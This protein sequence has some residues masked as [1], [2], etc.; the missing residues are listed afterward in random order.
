MT[1]ITI[2]AAEPSDAEAIHSILRCPGVVAGTLQLPWRP[3]EYTRQRFGTSSG[4]TYSLVAL[5]EARV[6][7]QLGL[8]VHTG[9]R[10]RDVGNFGMAVHD[11]FQGRGV[12]SALMAAML[13][14]ADG[15]LGL[16][17]LELEVWADNAAAI[18]LYEKY[19]FVIEG[20]GRQF[21]RRAGE[22]VDAL[23]MARLRPSQ[24]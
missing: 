12:G 19:G 22:L 4:G 14:L 23:Y 13:E 17:R 6:V 5:V 9:P 3:L 1:E 21:G 7:G 18:H 8:E 24:A 10:R 2:R 15:W 20:T 11:D 16:R